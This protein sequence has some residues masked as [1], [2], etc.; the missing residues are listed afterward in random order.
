MPTTTA[1]TVSENSQNQN[2]VLNFLRE[3]QHSF[4]A[5]PE[6]LQRALKYLSAFL[7]PQKMERKKVRLPQ[8]HGFMLVEEREIIYL[9]ASGSYT[10]VYLTNG[11]KVV[12]SKPLKD[13]IKILSSEFFERIHKSYIINLSYLKAYSR[14]QGGSVTME[15][16][17]E[18]LISRRRLAPFLDKMSRI[19]LSF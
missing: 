3:N 11:E 7:P 17:A 18:L 10:Q 6:L 12:V 8:A 9:E 13:F 2:S 14:L 1:I 5:S 19:T 16:G 15:N 4:A